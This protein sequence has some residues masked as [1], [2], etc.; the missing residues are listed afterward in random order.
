[1]IFPLETYPAL[2]AVYDSPLPSRAVFQPRKTPFVIARVPL[3]VCNVVGVAPITVC[4]AGTV[5]E[6]APFAL[7]VIVEFHCA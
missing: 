6:L 7:Y 1:M 4:E 3:F 5:P 2:P